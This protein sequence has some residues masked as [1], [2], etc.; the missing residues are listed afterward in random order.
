MVEAKDA[1]RAPQG[2]QTEPLN[3]ADARPRVDILTQAWA[4][5]RAAT[6]ALCVTALVSPARA[7]AWPVDLSHDV[8]PERERFVPL[9]GLDWFEVADPTVVGVEWRESARELLLIGLRR[10]RTHV[11]LG[12]GGRVALWLVRVGT[13]PLVDPAKEATARAACPGLELK[14]RGDEPVTVRVVSDG[15]HAALL[16]FFQ[17]DAFMARDLELELELPVLQH[18]LAGLQRAFGTISGASV[19]A[20]YLG[21]GLVLEGTATEAA[22]RRVLWTVAR[23]ALGRFALEDRVKVAKPA[24][25]PPGPD[26]A[27][28]TAPAAELPLRPGPSPAAV[29]PPPKEPPAAI[30]AGPP[31]R[32]SRT[33]K[34]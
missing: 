12:A 22:Y 19:E 15:C 26:T 14:R 17:T 29:P 18:Q 11:L 1:P 20:S 34:R 10:G 25:P 23:T 21:A 9:A 33:P 6:A 13:P 30:G 5:A 7:G 8:E 32:R 24:A 27:P 31:T 4:G 3:S 2:A 16:D 28:A